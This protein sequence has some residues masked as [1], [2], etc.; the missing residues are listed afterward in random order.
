VK[1]VC[2]FALIAACVATS[3]LSGQT[4]FAQQTTPHL[5]SCTKWDEY[6][7]EMGFWNKCSQPVIVLFMRLTTKRVTERRISPGAR[8]NTGLTKK[9]F[10]SWMST[11]CPVGFAPSVPFTFENQKAIIDSRYECVR[12]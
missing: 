12:K 10:T 7:N 11:R 5:E 9:Q 3:V 2:R 8:F 6:K 1:Q 4:V